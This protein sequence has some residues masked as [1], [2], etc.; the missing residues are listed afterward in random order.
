MS[1]KIETVRV[2]RILAR[3]KSYLVRE[4]SPAMTRMEHGA[5]GDDKAGD[6]CV[7]SRLRGQEAPRKPQYGDADE[8]ADHR[9]KTNPEDHETNSDHTQGNSDNHAC[10]SV[11]YAYCLFHV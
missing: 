8:N 10:Y 9:K 4:N 1:S 7:L 11:R 5:V 2:K 6:T 3:Q